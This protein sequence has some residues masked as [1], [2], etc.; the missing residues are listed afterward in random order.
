MFC[1]DGH[2]CTTAPS[3]EGLIIDQD[4]EGLRRELA[5]G[6]DPSSRCGDG[7]PVLVLAISL[8]R[9]E[10]ASLLLVHGANPN[11]T[12]RHGKTGLHFAATHTG[13]H[14]SR[15]LVKAGANAHAV[16]ERGKRH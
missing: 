11:A 10:M 1:Y 5:C 13:V 8:G 16:D 2:M 3:L 4:H 6:A 12:T 7:D 15:L 9:L 14:A